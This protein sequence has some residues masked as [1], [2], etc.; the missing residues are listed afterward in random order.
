VVFRA[1]VLSL[2]IV[3]NLL[4]RQFSPTTGGEYA[5]MV[6]S[7]RQHLRAKVVVSIIR[8][9]RRGRRGRDL[10][11]TRTAEGR[12]RAR[13]RGQHMRRPPKLNPMQQAEARQRRPK[14]ATLVE[15]ARS[16]DVS[17]ATISWLG[18]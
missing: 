1:F 6:W 3:S 8:P 14:C 17:L 5:L 9:G 16:Y 18:F 15:L 4:D 11:R 10:I 7:A 13:A 12:S 2:D